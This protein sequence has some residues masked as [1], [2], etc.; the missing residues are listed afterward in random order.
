MSSFPTLTRCRP[1]VIVLRY[2]NQ[3]EITTSVQHQFPDILPTCHECHIFR[4]WPDV[5]P[6]SVFRYHNQVEITTS[7]NINFLIISRLVINFIFS[8]IY[9][10]LTSISRYYNQVQKTTSAQHISFLTV[11]RLDMNA[12]FPNIGQMSARRQFCDIIIRS[13]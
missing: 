2:H 7:A 4:H 12:I 13:K 3:V 10:G 6:M 8:D 9:V 5:C 1:D 11:C